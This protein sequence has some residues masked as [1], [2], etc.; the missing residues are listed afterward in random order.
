MSRFVGIQIGA[1]S[2]V[3]EGVEQVLDPVVEKGAVN[4]VF[5]ATQAFDRG[6]AGRQTWY[7][8]WPGHGPQELDDV[9]I[10]GSFV[11][12]HDEYYGGSVLGPHRARDAEVAGFDALGD[13]IPAA[14]ERG[15]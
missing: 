6:L 7:R 4:A 10:G 1:I 15:V 12:Q 9:H 3:D 5:I 8:P 11:T 13:V 14:R 2:F